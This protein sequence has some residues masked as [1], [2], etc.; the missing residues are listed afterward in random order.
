MVAQQDGRWLDAVL[1]SD[2]D[3]GLCREKR[4]TRAAQRAVGHDVDL[5]LLAEVDNLLLRQSR[6]V[7]NLVDGGDDGSMREELLEVTLAVLLFGESGVRGLGAEK[8]V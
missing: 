3:N 6:V 8:W 5:V 4:T 2:L 7:F 1:L